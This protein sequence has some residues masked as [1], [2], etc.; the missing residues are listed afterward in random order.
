VGQQILTGLDLSTG[1]AFL[2]PNDI[3]VLEKDTGIVHR[4]LNGKL[5][6]EH[7][8]RAPVATE[9]ERG[10]LGIAIAKNNDNG[11]GGPSYAFLY[12]TKVVEKQA[13][14]R[15]AILLQTQILT[16]PAYHRLVIVFTDMI[17]I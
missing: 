1:M 4:I 10:L 11:N 15:L 5:L 9:G 16:V 6:P 8:L 12:Y 2:G 3:L 7:V 13:M 14:M 17:W